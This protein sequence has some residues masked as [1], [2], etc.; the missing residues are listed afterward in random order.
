LEF[1]MKSCLVQKLAPVSM[2][3]VLAAVGCAAPNGDSSDDPPASA[4]ESEVRTRNCPASFTLIIENVTATP[5][6]W[7]AMVSEWSVRLTSAQRTDLA[8]IQSQFTSGGSFTVSGEI[9]TRHNG[10]CTYKRPSTTGRVPSMKLYSKGGKDILE[11]GIDVDAN[12]VT[13][14]HRVYAF[15]SSYDENGFTF[16]SDEVLVD[17]VIGIPDGPNLVVKIGT[18]NIATA[19]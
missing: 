11:L 10:V 1:I 8:T 15:P 16:A 14:R 3:L 18:A 5:I 19:P 4:T 12:P 17:G 13:D 2:T 7:T 9:A 6:P